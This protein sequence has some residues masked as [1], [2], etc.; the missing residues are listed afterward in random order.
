MTNYRL[1]NKINGRLAQL[2]RDSVQYI[3]GTIAPAESDFETNDI[4]SLDK[5]LDY[6]YAK[7]PEMELFIQPKWMGSRCQLYLHRDT[8]ELNFAVT[9]NG[10][11][12]RFGQIYLTR[13]S[14]YLKLLKSRID[15]LT[16][17]IKRYELLK[18]FLM[19]N[20][21]LGV[22]SGLI[23]REFMGLV[24]SITTE[25]NFLMEN[26][27]SEA[28]VK[29]ID[30]ELCQEFFSVSWHYVEEGTFKEFSTL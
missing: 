18:L 1:H 2:K 22:L 27:Y 19:V 10:F 9:R 26:G 13:W 21:F 12:V 16:V 11:K 14:Q 8:P 15:F 30:E 25:D 17:V 29:T 20:F 3:S 28:I 4:E 7:D 23:E 24:H 5:A 6:F